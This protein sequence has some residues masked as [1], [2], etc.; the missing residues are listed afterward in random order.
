MYLITNIGE[1]CVVPRG[2]VG[3]ARMDDWPRVKDAELLIDG[4]RIAWFGPAAQ[5][6]A[7]ITIDAEYDAG[8]G[9]VVPG[10]VDCHTHVVFA[11]LRDNE[12]V[13]RNAGRTY[14][15][16]AAQGGGIRVSVAAVRQ[17]SLEQLVE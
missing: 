3:G 1:L 5:R 17:A 16:I 8:G 7:N 6:K 13:M 15:E 10:L 2:P 9:C 4:E 11:G 12:F 14:T